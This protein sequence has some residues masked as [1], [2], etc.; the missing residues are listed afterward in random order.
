[1]PTSTFALPLLSLLVAGCVVAANAPGTASLEPF[2]VA[3]TGQTRWVIELPPKDK[4]ADWRV[5]LIPGKQM[6]I[7]CN[8]H[9]LQGKLETK[10]VQGWG[11]DYYELVTEGQVFSTRMGCPDTSKRSAFVQGESLTVPY[12][13]R[14]LLVV[15]ADKAYAIKYRI[16]Q[17][18]T[19]QTAQVR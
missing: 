19:V 15:L 13:S 3:P 4:E 11:Y 2:P 8:H 16:W 7:D 10:T 12:N 6:D 14:L 5:E 9:G 17:A 1:M 18:G